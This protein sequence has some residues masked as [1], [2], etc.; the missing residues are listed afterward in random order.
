MVV[1]PVGLSFKCSSTKGDDAEYPK[2][3]GGIGLQLLTIGSIGQ[4]CR[5]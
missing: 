3:D 2:I 1:I 5:P 4:H